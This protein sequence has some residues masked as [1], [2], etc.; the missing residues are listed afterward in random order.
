MTRTFVVGEPPDEL[1]EYHRLVKE[2]LDRRSRHEGR[3]APASTSSTWRASSSR[4]RPADQPL[5]E[6]G[7]VLETA[8]STG[9]ATASGSRCT[10]RRASAAAA[11]GSS[12]PA[13]WSRSSRAST[14][15]ASAACRLEDLVL[16]TE[17]G[18]ENLTDF[19]YDLTP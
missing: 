3:R 9:S 1:V 10:R 16:V 12:S 4:R 11:T 17:D 18:A 7:E 13:T 5:E 15:R 19:P 6:P 8:S 2:A 14:G